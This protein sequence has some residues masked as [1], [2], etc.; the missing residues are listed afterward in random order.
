MIELANNTE[1]GLAA[2]FYTQDIN[3]GAGE[4]GYPKLWSSASSAA[5]TPF[6]P[7]HKR[8]LAA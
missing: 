3:R 4:S 5:T 1:Y 7:L 2:Y 6:P 8:H